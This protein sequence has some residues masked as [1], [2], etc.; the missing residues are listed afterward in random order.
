M[1]AY[2]TNIGLVYQTKNPTDIEK[3][4]KEAYDRGYW[5]GIRHAEYEQ[6]MKNKKSKSIFG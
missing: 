5:D 3:Q 1:C 4:L 2:D 6:K